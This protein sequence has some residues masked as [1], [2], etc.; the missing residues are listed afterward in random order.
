MI[1]E[2]PFT[3]YDRPQASRNAKGYCLRPNIL[4]SQSVYVNYNCARYSFHIK[5]N[6][7]YET[8]NKNSRKS[9]RRKTYYQRLNKHFLPIKF[10]YYGNYYCCTL[11]CRQ[12]MRRVLIFIRSFALAFANKVGATAKHIAYEAYR[13]RKYVTTFASYLH[14]HK[15]FGASCV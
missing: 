10:G 1:C 15:Y 8:N 12:S 13:A 9:A 14:S 6:K 11:T 4:R 3:F 5:V 2:L 7:G